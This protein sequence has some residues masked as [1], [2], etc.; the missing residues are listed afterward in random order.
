MPNQIQVL[1]LDVQRLVKP[2]R[3]RTA[4]STIP[5]GVDGRERA[6]RVKNH[7]LLC[8]TR[9]RFLSIAPNGQRPPEANDGQN[10]SVP[11]AAAWWH[12]GIT[13]RHA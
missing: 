11:I 13:Y 9:L 1:D 5:I 3:Q 10:D 8:A 4:N 2:G 7:D 6:M 12:F